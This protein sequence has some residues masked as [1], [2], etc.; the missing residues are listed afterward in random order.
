MFR[1]RTKNRFTQLHGDPNVDVRCA[2]SPASRSPGCSLWCAPSDSPGLH[3]FP[4]Y[5][6]YTYMSLPLVPSPRGHC[7]CIVIIV[8]VSCHVYLLKHSLHKLNC[9]ISEH[10]ITVDNALIKCSLNSTF[11]VKEKIE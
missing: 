5:L 11:F 8:F 4:D 2:P 1:E 3:H 10:I 6:P 9:R 7:F